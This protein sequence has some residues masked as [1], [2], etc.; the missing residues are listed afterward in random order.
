M[1]FLGLGTGGSYPSWGQMI[2]AGQSYLTSGWWMILFPGVTLFVTLFAANNL[3]KEINAHF[4]PGL[5][6]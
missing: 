6:K 1:S 2:E 3:G 4:N 5:E